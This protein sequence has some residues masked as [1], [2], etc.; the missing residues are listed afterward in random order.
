MNMA[1]LDARSEL[2]QDRPDDATGTITFGSTNADNELVATVMVDDADGIVVDY[3]D[4][5]VGILREWSRWM[6]RRL[7]M[8]MTADGSATEQTTMPSL[9]PSKACT[10]AWLWN[11]KMTT[12][13]PSES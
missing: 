7:T 1:A 5:R 2:V 11:S 6:G 12:G 4:L 10:S 3:L 9:P 8:T 13:H